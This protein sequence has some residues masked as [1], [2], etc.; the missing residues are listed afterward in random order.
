MLEAIA[1]EAACA[2]QQVDFQSRPSKR[3]KTVNSFGSTH[4]TV[5]RVR[6]LLQ[7]LVAAKRDLEEERDHLVAKSSYPKVLPLMTLSAL[8]NNL[9]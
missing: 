5:E 9:H 1:L 7:F 4:D 8:I 2:E 3:L 6:Q